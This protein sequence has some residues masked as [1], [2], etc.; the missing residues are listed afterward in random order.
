MIFSGVR[1]GGINDG[2]IFA[3]AKKRLSVFD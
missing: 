1:L 3:A 2:R